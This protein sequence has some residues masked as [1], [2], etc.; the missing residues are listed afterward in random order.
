MVCRAMS[1]FAVVALVLVS[2]LPASSQVTTGTVLGTIKDAQGGVIPGATVV[3]ISQTK[4]TKS[5]PAITN[6]TGDYVFPNV[7]ADTYTVEVVMEGFKTV[8]RTGVEVSGGDRV[9]VG[10]LV[11]DVGG[12]AETVNVTAESPLVQASSG[13]RSFAITTSS[14]ENLPLSNR[15]FA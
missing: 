8:R 2:V 14:V 15:N 3:L 4:G 12:T 11:L 6:A 7:T 10:G 9:A 13:E 1:A 5:A